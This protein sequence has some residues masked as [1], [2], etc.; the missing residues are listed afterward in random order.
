MYTYYWYLIRKQESQ[1]LELDTEWV[2]VCPDF[3]DVFISDAELDTKTYRDRKYT[4]QAS[5]LID[6]KVYTMFVRG[7]TIPSG[8]TRMPDYFYFSVSISDR[9]TQ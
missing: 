5:K 6:N 9:E 1:F 3:P 2:L 4:T 7:D 8:Q